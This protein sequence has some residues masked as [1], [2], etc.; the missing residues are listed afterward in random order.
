[1]GDLP[2]LRSHGYGPE[3]DTCLHAAI[4]VAALLEMS[5]NPVTTRAT[6]TNRAGCVQRGLG[7]EMPGAKRGRR[8]AAEDTPRASILQQN[9][10]GISDVPS[11]EAREVV[12][13]LP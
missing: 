6:T 1:V 9:T 2:T 12:P 10:E 13:P 5:N 7:R 4:P 3:D 8:D 11:G